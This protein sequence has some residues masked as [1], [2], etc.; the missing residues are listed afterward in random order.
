VSAKYLLPCR[1]GQQVVVEPRQAGETVVCSCGQTLPIP[2]MLEMAAL[3]AAPPAEMPPPPP[4]GA[5]GWRQRMVMFGTVM[6]V[7]AVLAGV[8]LARTRPIA[9]IDT[10]DPDILRRDFKGFPPT[11]SW[12]VWRDMK[13]G[14]DR[15]TDPRYE[16]AL[17]RFRVW[18]AVT[19]GLALVGLALLGA[20]VAKRRQA[21]GKKERRGDREPKSG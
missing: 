6:L 16:A 12:H 20:G 2:G 3:E 9:P 11:F 18:E 5:W 19:I 7:G 17:L 21:D 14:L 8:W 13:Q 1:C 4:G 15:R 10:I